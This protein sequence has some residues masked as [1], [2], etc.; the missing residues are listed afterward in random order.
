[1]TP[2]DLDA[3]RRAMK[4]GEGYQ[5]REPQIVVFPNPM[6]VEG[7]AEWF[8]LATDLAASAQYHALGLKPWQVEPC[9]ASN[10]VD[11]GWGG[12]PDEVALRR[13]M[14]KLGLSRFEPDPLQAIAEAERAKIQT[15]K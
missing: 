13:K 5:R 7:T 2:V 15:A 6:P 8:K 4:W 12:K 14:I 1:M 9:N 11:N 10:V 3:L